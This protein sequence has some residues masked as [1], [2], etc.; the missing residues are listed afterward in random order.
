MEA[1]IQFDGST[2]AHFDI[3]KGVKQG[4]VLAPTLFS[5]YFA[6]L[7]RFAFDGSHDGIYIRSRTDGSL[8]NLARLRAKTKTVE[9]LLRDLLFADDA[10]L[11]SHKEAGLQG[12]INN[13]AKACDLFS[14]TIS[15]KKT[16]VM[17]QGTTVP[18]VIMLNGNALK[19][20][21]KFTYLGS[22]MTNNLSLDQE[23]NVRIGKAAA[24]YG[25]LTKRDV[26][27]STLKDFSIQEKTW[28]QLAVD[29]NRWRA[30]VTRRASP[31]LA[32]PRR[33]SA[34]IRWEGASASRTGDYFCACQLHANTARL[35]IITTGQISFEL[36][37]ENR[38]DVVT[39]DMYRLDF[40]AI[41]AGDFSHTGS[42]RGDD[43]SWL[44]IKTPSSLHP[45]QP[46][47]SGQVAVENTEVKFGYGPHS[48]DRTKMTRHFE[49]VLALALLAGAVYPAKSMAQQPEEEQQLNE[50]A[51]PDIEE[52]EMLLKELED[53]VEEEV[54]AGNNG[55]DDHMAGLF[56][57]RHLPGDLR[58]PNVAFGRPTYQSSTGHGGV[59]VRA[60]DGN[61]SPHWANNSCTHTNKE[62]D[63]WWYVD[64]GRQVTIDHVAIVNLRDRRKRITPFDVHVGD[65][66]NVASNPR[67]GGHHHFPLTETEKVVNCGGLRGRYVGIRL[68]GRK[69]VLTL[70]EVEVY[71]GTVAT[72]L[73][74]LPRLILSLQPQHETASFCF[75][76]HLPSELCLGFSPDVEV[77]AQTHE[78]SPY[79]PSYT[80]FYWV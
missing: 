4:C 48:L 6:A 36:F 8:F 26:C 15:V 80:D 25:K 32:G 43:E 20:V 69:R 66:T 45:D 18:P 46:T 56:G 2:S 24:A 54:M 21:E 1:C 73:E 42:L 39:M 59:S 5:I 34:E 61:R 7:L 19:S 37:Q 41:K 23:L 9:S 30:A 71:A 3:K 40:E 68:P 65:S 70:C 57:K 22:V 74:G 38:M 31:P 55:I 63:P 11:V 44:Q 77:P 79:K 78:G 64:L 16:E 35:H 12:H 10:A 28:E 17:G 27:R 76:S 14:L 75:F 13:L 47:A 33:H 51:S 58:D 62:N 60:V 53:L 49:F 29:R 72:S 50:D 67:C 52:V